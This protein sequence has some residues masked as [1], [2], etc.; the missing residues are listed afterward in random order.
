MYMSKNMKKGRSSLA[1]DWQTFSVKDQILN[2]FGFAGEMV[3][4]KITKLCY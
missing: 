4:V 1:R 3:S 2:M